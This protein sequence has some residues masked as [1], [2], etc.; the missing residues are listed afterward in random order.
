M[1]K[2]LQT[3]VKT[4]CSFDRYVVPYAHWCGRC[5]HCEQNGD[6]SKQRQCIIIASDVR[7]EVGV[8]VELLE[9]IW[10]RREGIQS[11]M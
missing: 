8:L 6:T 5:V 2:R 1:M 4:E 3:S 11:T 7:D 10:W 9:F